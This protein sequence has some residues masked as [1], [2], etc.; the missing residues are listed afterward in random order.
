[1]PLITANQGR[2]TRESV[3]FLRSSS[4]NQGHVT[5]HMV[6]CIKPGIH[7][8][9]HVI[10]DKMPDFYFKTKHTSYQ[11]VILKKWNYSPID[12]DKIVMHHYEYMFEDTPID[13]TQAFVESLVE[14]DLQNP[15][16]I[17]SHSNVFVRVFVDDAEEAFLVDMFT[18]KKT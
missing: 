4:N 16:L 7:V 6:T 14:S 3:S 15:F 17:R 5:G 10:E 18:E 1:M 12:P 13:M 11:P 8:S 9:G 2:A